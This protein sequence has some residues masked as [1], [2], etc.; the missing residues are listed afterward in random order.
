M[1]IVTEIAFAHEDGALG[2]TLT[3]HP[4]LDVTIVR[5]ARTAPGE[6]VHLVRFGCDDIE[7]VLTALENDHSVASVSRTQW[8]EEQHILGV[9]FASDAKLLNPHVTDKNGLVLEARSSNTYQSP[10]GWRERWLLPNGDALREIW[11]HAREEGFEFDIVDLQQQGDT[12]PDFTGN[13]TLTPEQRDGLIT[14]YEHGYFTEPRET[15]LDEL[16]ADMGLS[17]TA[18]GGRIKRGMKTLIWQTLIH[19]DRV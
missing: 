2:D 11:Q 15:G 3:E 10:R 4:E 1:T 6:S 8:F 18:V 7:M 13:V 14:A 19:E 17:P 9:E 5:D 16:A 12:T